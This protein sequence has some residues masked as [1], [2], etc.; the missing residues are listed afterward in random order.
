MKKTILLIAVLA[1]LTC[2]NQAQTVTDINGN[3]YNTVVI[4]TQ[5]W[6]TENLKTTKLNNGTPIPLVSDNQAWIDLTTPGYCWYGN[7]STNGT[8]YGALYNWYTVNTNN[9]CPTGWSVP[10]DAEWSTLIDYLGGSSVAGDKLKEEGTAHWVMN[11]NATNESG[12]TGLPGGHRGG[13]GAFDLLRYIGSF[14]SST[15]VDA[16][17]SGIYN[18]TMYGGLVQYFSEGKAAGKS[19][20][21]I[22][23]GSTSV[24]NTQKPSINLILYPNPSDSRVTIRYTKS[25]EATLQVIDMLGKVIIEEQFIESIEIGLLNKGLYIVR[26]ID[27]LDIITEKLTIQ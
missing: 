27:E 16:N 17:F 1:L 7:L 22:K 3:V 23:G 5:E 13:Y 26:L 19:V 2:K 14:W 20:R 18:L 10:T 15:E 24:L 8:T 11:P 25:K 9:L 21:C 12:F 4:G 6:L